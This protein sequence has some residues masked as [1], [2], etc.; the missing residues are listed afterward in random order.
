[1]FKKLFNDATEEERAN[2]IIFPYLNIELEV[3][4]GAIK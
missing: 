4:H 2:K 1:M 3:D